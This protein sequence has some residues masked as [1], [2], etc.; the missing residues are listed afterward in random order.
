MTGPGLSARAVACDAC[1]ALPGDP[2]TSHG[3]TRIR[4][5]DVHQARTRAYAAQQ[6]GAAPSPTIREDHDTP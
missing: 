3:G 2:C 4:R 5:H 6:A 1:G